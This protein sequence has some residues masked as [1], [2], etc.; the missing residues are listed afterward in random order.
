MSSTTEEQI[1]LLMDRAEIHDLIMAYARYVDTKD[2]EAFADLFA[3]DGC[4][5]LPFGKL[6]KKNLARS[7]AN[8]L[9]PFQGTQHLFTNVS[10]SID[11]DVATTNHYLQAT[12]VPSLAEGGS[13]ADIG[14]WYDNTCRRTSDG[15]KFVTVDLTFVWSGGIPFRPGDPNA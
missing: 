14:G 4:I 6:E 12:H 9:G 10:I 1:Q 15:W 7:T 5:I 8:V 13:H 3:D 2:W 11:G